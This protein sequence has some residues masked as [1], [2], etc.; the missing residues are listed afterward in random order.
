MAGDDGLKLS[1]IRS[2]LYTVGIFVIF[3]QGGL[4][5]ARRQQAVP[6]QQS[7]QVKPGAT[8]VEHPIPKLMADAEDKFRNMLARQSKTLGQAVAEYKRRNGRDPPKGFDEWFKFAVEKNVQIIDD[9]DAITEDLAPFMALTGVELRRRVGQ[10]RRIYSDA[11][12]LH[13][14]K[15]R[16]RSATSHP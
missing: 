3:L 9:Y 10:V 4:Y 16:R 6:V 1:Q 11:V 2:L 15:Y 13:G 14:T 5:A 7:V 12:I 8:I